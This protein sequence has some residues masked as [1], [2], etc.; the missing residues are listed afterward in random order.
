MCVCKLRSNEW[1]SKYNTE[2]GLEAKFTHQLCSLE[3]S[4]P[5]NVMYIEVRDKNKPS[6]KPLAEGKITVN[7]FLSN[8]DT[9]IM[10]PL[11]RGGDEVGE[12]AFESPSGAEGAVTRMS[13]PSAGASSVV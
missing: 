13:E 4:A 7:E 10:V 3:Y 1:R 6:M 9:I 2:P 11:L 5:G 8:Q 12:I